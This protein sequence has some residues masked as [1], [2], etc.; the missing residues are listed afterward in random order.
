M[1]CYRFCK[2]YKDYFESARAKGPNKI[3]FAALFL[4]RLVIKQWLQHKQRHNEV[5][6]MTR[7]EFKNFFQKNFGN[8]KAFKDGIWSK[9]KRDSQYQDK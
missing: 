5:T 1:D 8:S 3:P 2:Q 6:P 7:Q 4:C 9:I